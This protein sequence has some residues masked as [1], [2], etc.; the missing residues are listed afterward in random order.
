V[1]VVTSPPIN[2]N[3]AT[4]RGEAPFSGPFEASGALYLVTIET[5]PANA[6]HVWK[7]SDSGSTWTLKD[8]A[9]QPGATGLGYDVLLIGTVLYI[10]PISNPGTATFGV[11]AFDTATDTYGALVPSGY[12]M[13]GQKIRIAALSDNSITLFY[14]KPDTS[15][16][17]TTFAAGVFGVEVA[18]AA[19]GSQSVRSLVADAGDVLHAFWSKAVAGT[20]TLNHTTITAGVVGAPQAVHAAAGF[21]FFVNAQRSNAAVWTIEDKLVFPS[22]LDDGTLAGVWVGTPI[23]APVWSFELVDDIDWTGAG[24]P[25]ETDAETFLFVSGGVLYAFWIAL[26]YSD[27][28]IIDREYFKSNDGSG[29]SAPTIYYDAV[30][31]PQVFD[32]VADADQFIHFTNFTKLTSGAFGSFIALETPTFCASF[33]LLDVPCDIVITVQPK[34]GGVTGAAVV[35]PVGEVFALPPVIAGQQYPIQILRATEANPADNFEY[36]VTSGSP[37]PKVFIGGPVQGAPDATNPNPPAPTPNNPTPVTDS[38]VGVPAY[39][40]PQ[41]T[42]PDPSTPVGPVTYTWRSKVRLIA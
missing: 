9:N 37:P 5:T 33:Y 41:I 32:P 2:I 39:G 8:S 29:W 34:S 26:D 38:T 17:F 6:I 14:Q 24:F 16:K 21:P 12:T 40:T 18:F 15:L 4:D 3:N 7:S 27:G 42:Q 22:S 19:A 28:P 31:D 13:Q 25:S 11:I 1:P 35:V 10:A 30:T 23:A 20:T 36:S